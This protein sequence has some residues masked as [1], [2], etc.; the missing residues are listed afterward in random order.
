MPNCKN[1]KNRRYIGHES[2]PMGLGICAGA[3][4]TGRRMIGQD[5]NVWVVK[6]STTG[7]KRWVIEF[8]LDA[9]KYTKTPKKTPKKTPTNM[10]QHHT[11][12]DI[13]LTQLAI[14]MLQSVARRLL[15]TRKHALPRT[16]TELISLI[17]KLQ[18][19]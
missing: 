12:D 19:T 5:S 15:G 2:S 3:E 4:S 11:L 9:N 7:R 13:P 8:I 18:S 6:Q 14:P 1:D 10:P 17:H 16:R